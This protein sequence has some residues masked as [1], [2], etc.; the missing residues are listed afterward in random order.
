MNSKLNPDIHPELLR[1]IQMGQLHHGQ[2]VAPDKRP[3]VDRTGLNPIPPTPEGTHLLK[4]LYNCPIDTLKKQLDHA[5]RQALSQKDLAETERLTPGTFSCI[6]HD[7]H[8]AANLRTRPVV[9]IKD[10]EELQSMTEA[11]EAIAAEATALSD[12][13]STLAQTY[14]HLE[15][16]RF[17]KAVAKYGLNVKEQSYQVNEKEG[18]IELVEPKCSE[19]VPIKK[20]QDILRPKEVSK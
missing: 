1:R 9:R 15:H 7:L 19:C 13:V 14:N 2:R 8:C 16:E 6:T 17:Q 4:Q 18:C 5:L 3:S 12:Q 10:D 11:L 20:L